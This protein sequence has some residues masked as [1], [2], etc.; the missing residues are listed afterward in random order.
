MCLV[1]WVRALQ[2]ARQNRCP[3][4]LLFAAEYYL[5]SHKTEIEMEK[6]PVI[7]ISNDD[8][9]RAKGFNEIVECAAKFGDVIALAPDQTQSGK[10]HAITMYDPLYLTLR[11]DEEHIK[12]YSCNGTPVDWLLPELGITPDL[13]LSGI[14]HGSNAA[15]NVLYSGTMGAAIEA[16]FYGAPSI[17]LS[18]DDHSYDA[19]FEATIAFAEKIIPAILALGKPSEPLCLNI[20]VPVARPEEIRGHRICRQTRGFWKEEFFCRQDPRGRDYFWLT[21]GFCNHE[22]NAEDTDEWALKNNYIAVVP[23]KIDLTDYARM[24][25]LKGLKL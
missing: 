7:F 24:E 13:N 25:M 14:N 23:V 16:S 12:V 3:K 6:R 11:R 22:P 20:N 18:L 19:D 10:A 21:G 4:F 2:I 9:Y 17:G 1:L 8:G 5:C 15:I